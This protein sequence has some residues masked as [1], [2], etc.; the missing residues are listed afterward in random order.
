MADP[1][2]AAGALAEQVARASY[3]RLLAV[4]AAPTG[5]IFAA[6]DAIADAFE[7]AL[8]TWPKRGIPDNP[9][10]W[11]L[12]V[13]R[14]RLRDLYRSAATRTA[15]PL[16]E[17]GLVGE[18]SEQLGPELDADAIPDKRL[19]LM[20]VCAHPAIEVGIRT[21]LMLQTVLGFDAAQIGRVFAVPSTA[22]AQR[23]VRA[24]RRIR[25]ARIPFAIPS[26]QDMPSR[27]PAVLEAIYGAYAIDWQPVSGLTE[28]GS[29]SAEARYL[30]VTLATL[31]DDPEALGLAA[32]IS[33]SLARAPARRPDTFVPLGEQDPNLWDRAMIADGESLLLRAHAHRRIGRFQ[34][35]AAIQSVHC[36]RAVSGSTDWGALKKLA[37]ALVHVAPTRGALVSLAATIAE[38]DGPAA[39]LDYLDSIE[40]V[41]RFQPAWATRAHLLARLGQA[42]A[43]AEAYAKA[44]SLTTDAASR[45]FLQQ[46]LG[47]L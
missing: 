10:G 2:V 14:N 11:L 18:A 32:L 42:D 44:I 7:S 30:A 41:A 36:N 23:L 40:D 12:T 25:D 29:L 16:D 15:V 33:L 31:L 28:L 20:F 47:E 1:G 24:K 22:M 37:E 27:L 4:L 9:Q 39:G 46:R 17:A 21:P 38:T 34:L 45:R 5:D 19:Q 35:E 3:G 43:A 8:M 26:L 13:A 6:E